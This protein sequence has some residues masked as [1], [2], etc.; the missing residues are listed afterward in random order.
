MAAFAVFVFLCFL[1]GAFLQYADSDFGFEPAILNIPE[2]SEDNVTLLYIGPNST[3]SIFLKVSSARSQVAML[4]EGSFNLTAV[5]NNSLSVPVQSGHIGITTLDFTVNQ[6]ASA[7]VLDYTVK[8]LRARP[9]FDEALNY[10]L[11][12]FLV[13]NAFAMGTAVEWPLVVK[14]LKRPHGVAIGVLSQFVFMPLLAF[15]FS[16]AFSLAD[17]YAIGLL[18]VGSS[19]GGGLSNILTFFLDA[20]LPLSMTMTFV[21]TVLAL[22][23][24]PLSLFI[25]GRAFNFDRINVPY[26]TIVTSLVPVTIAKVLG[27]L[28]RHKK[29]RI[30]DKVM[31]A[32]RPFSALFVIAFVVLGFMVNTHFIY[33]PW[34]PIVADFLLPLAGFIIG[35]GLAKMLCLDNTRAKTVSIETGVQNGRLASAMIRLSFPQPEAD[36][37]FC[38]SF[39]NGMFQVGIGLLAVAVYN[40]YKC[41]NPTTEE[42]KMTNLEGL[43]NPTT[44]EEKIANLEGLENPTTEE[45]KITNLEGLKNPIVISDVKE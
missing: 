30:A 16:K 20:D 9:P 35:F 5:S 33:T 13:V 19:P 10:L 1:P 3:D 15:S 34:Q 32:I 8:V 22:G 2:R 23:M 44:E 11:I 45:E 41:K 12:P 26:S 36:L 43:E 31:K 28:L 38:V 21:S 27:I 7:T 6:G 24:M 4:K 18:M 29:P 39:L 42:V 37:S 25:Y 17:V 40:I 14:V